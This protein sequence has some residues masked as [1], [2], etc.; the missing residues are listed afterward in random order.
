[1]AWSETV[2]NELDMKTLLK[3]SLTTY[4]SF[5]T[6]LLCAII[7]VFF[8]LIYGVPNRMLGSSGDSLNRR[9]RDFLE[10]Y[11]GAE[12][13]LK[14]NDLYAAGYLGYIYPPMLAFLIMPLAKL[15]IAQAAWVWLIIKI[16]LL[17]LCGLLAAKEVQRRLEQPINW[18][19]LAIIMLFGMLI[20]I[21]KLRTEMN[22]QQSNLL[23]LLC[24]VL[25]LQWLDRRPLLCGL[26]LGFGANIKYVTLV[27]LPYLLLRKRF[28]TAAATVAGTVMWALLPALAVGWEQNIN[29]LIK[30]VGGLANL[31]RASAVE[32]GTAKVMGPAFGQSIP[33]FAV[34]YFGARDAAGY[35]GHTAMSIAV[36]IAVALLFF[37][38]VWGIYRFAKIP[39]F[40]NRGGRL[41][42]EDII[43]GIVALEWSGLI[44]IV[45]AFSPQTSSPHF[46]MLL[47]PCIV[48]VSVL[49]M[50]RGQISGFPLIIGLLLL[51]AGLS[52]PP[53]DREVAHSDIYLLWKRISWGTWTVLIM[54]LTLLWTGLRKLKAQSGHRKEI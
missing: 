49:F 34:R 21:D 54:Y 33:A 47:L 32:T 23:V 17:A 24:F 42:T 1:M 30:A 5:Q 53:G 27:A 44:V 4:K 40:L 25:A 36:V 19:S 14:G 50:P 3:K 37:L 28:K 15:S 18:I 52:L 29:Y 7:A 41:E 48:A 2:S 6:A 35:Y 46:S 9:Y 16:G 12:A 39:L 26:A 22:M 38:A 31:S 43:P 20:N 8:W 10:F 13:L 51:M 11:S 45:L